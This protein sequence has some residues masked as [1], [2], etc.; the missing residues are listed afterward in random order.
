MAHRLLVTVVGATGAQGGAVVRSLIETGKFKVPSF[1][2]SL[3]RNYCWF[4][5]KDSWFDA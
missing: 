3:L 4:F 5:S 1:L 2:M